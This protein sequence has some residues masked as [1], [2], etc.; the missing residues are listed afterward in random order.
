MLVKTKLTFA[1]ATR[2][3]MA[4]EQNDQDSDE[5]AGPEDLIKAVSILITCL[6]RLSY[7]IR[8]PAAHDQFVNTANIDTSFFE[9]H[10][11]HHVQSKFPDAEDVIVRRLGK[12][13]SR[14]RHYLKYR[15]DHGKKLSQGVAVDDDGNTIAITESTIASTLPDAARLSNNRPTIY[16]FDSES[17][18]SDTTYATSAYAEGRLQPPAM[19]ESAKNGDPFEC[20]LC[21]LLI[22]VTN[23]QAWKY[24]GDRND[25]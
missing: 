9:T 12:A 17:I 10:D 1:L 19:P 15:E 18:A 14:R 4:A 20:C 3:R 6:I 16:E 2:M 5:E 7:V 21:H 8:E 13:I 24:V 22:T 25:A 11:I 23:P